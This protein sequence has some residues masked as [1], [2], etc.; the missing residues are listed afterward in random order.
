MANTRMRILRA[1]V[2]AAVVGLCAS[3]IAGNPGKSASYSSM[4][5][6]MSNTAN[7]WDETA[8]EANAT[9]ATGNS[10]AS[11]V[12]CDCCS[13]TWYGQADLLVWWFKPNQAPALVTTSPDGTP[14]PSAGVLGAPG[15]EV[16][17]GGGGLDDNYRPGVRLTM[18]YWLDDCQLSGLEFTGFA[19]GDGANSG[20]FYAHS[21]GTPLSPILARPFNNVLLGQPDSQLVAFPGLVEGSVQTETN[22]ELYSVAVLLRRNWLRDCD[23]RV[24]L[25]GG[26]RYLRFRESLTIREQLTSTDPGGVIPVGTTFG[27]VDAFGTENDFHGGEVGLST[28]INRG[29][30]DFDILT[31]LAFGNMHQRATIG[32][33]TA[34]TVPTQPALLGNGG[35]LALPTNIGTY[36]WDEFALIP[37]LNLNLRYRW[38]ERLSLEMGYSLLWITDIARTGGQIDMNVNPSQLPANGGN[39]VGPAAP[40]PVLDHSDMWIQGLN[41]GVVWEF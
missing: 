25:I 41:L 32:G 34:I 17:V 5:A 7:L 11:G 6:S 13:P 3:S 12:Y 23:R 26:Y 22:S 35:L 21:V 18:G 29:C 39:L 30:W 33:Q 19:V 28:L 15:T 10:C 1:V 16:L 20:N 37:E 8:E 24:D 2:A 38:S 14:R 4:P 9:P 27:I 31:K 36:S 40:L